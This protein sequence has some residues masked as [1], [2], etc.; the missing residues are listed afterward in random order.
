MNVSVIRQSTLRQLPHKETKANYRVRTSEERV[1]S[2]R[3]CIVQIEYSCVDG[4][5]VRLGRP[6]TIAMW[7]EGATNT[8]DQREQQAMRL[9]SEALCGRFHENTKC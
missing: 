2:W 5:S 8:I 3:I 7:R 4:L 6:G 1:W 9:V